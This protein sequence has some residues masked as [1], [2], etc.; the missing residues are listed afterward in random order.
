VPALVLMFAGIIVVIRS[1]DESPAL[2]SAPL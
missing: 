2:E 1:A